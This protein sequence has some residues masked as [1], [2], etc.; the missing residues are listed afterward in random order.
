MH[1]KYTHRFVGCLH[2]DEIYGCIAN[3][4]SNTEEGNAKGI[5]EHLDASMKRNVW[6]I[7]QGNASTPNCV[8][9]AEQDENRGLLPPHAIK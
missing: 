7:V 4:C 2:I 6:M 9:L 5:W 1:K 3:L 8:L